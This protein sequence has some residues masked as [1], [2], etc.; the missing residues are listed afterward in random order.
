MKRAG[1]P[2]VALAMALAAFSAAASSIRREEN[3]TRKAPPTAQGMQA[4]SQDQREHMMMANESHHV[5]AMAFHQNLATFAKA[6]HEHT[7]HASSVN[8]GFVRT[9]QIEMRRCFGEMRLHHEEHM[10]TMSAEMQKKMGWMRKQ[11][12]THHKELINLLDALE[13]EADLAS[14]DAKT[15]STLAAGIHTHCDGISTMDQGNKAETVSNSGEVLNKV[16]LKNSRPLLDE[17]SLGTDRRE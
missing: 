13:K 12:E 2:V 7:E 17:S 1:F 4:M 11:M 14:P 8:A 16:D 6:L 15:V 5:L 10:K 3:S 9:A